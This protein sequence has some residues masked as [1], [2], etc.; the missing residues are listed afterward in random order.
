MKFSDRISNIKPSFIREIL[1]AS[2]NPDIIS[3][4]GGLPNKDYFPCQAL[5]DIT[6]TLMQNEAQ[7]LLQY[8][9]SEGEYQLRSLIS[10]RYHD[11]HQMKVPVDNILITNGSQ[12]AFDLIGKTLINEGDGIV[13]EAPAYLGAIQALMMYQPE[14]LPVPIDSNGLD[15]KALKQAM[16]ANPKIVYSVPN[17]Q[18]PTGFSYS[19]ENRES[20]VGLVRDQS[21]LIIEDDPYGDIRFNNEHP[22]S[23]YQYLPEQTILLG[24][25][26][27]IIS[28]GLR[29]GW[30]VAPPAVMEKL[31]IAKQ[32]S[33]LHT[34][35]L[36]QRIIAEY[37][38]AGHLP[39]HIKTLCEVYGKRC[40][41]MGEILDDLFG[42]KIERSY[43]QGGMFM[44]VKFP[45]SELSR[46]NKIKPIDTMAL[47]NKSYENGVAF[48]PGQPFYIETANQPNTNNSLRLNYSNGSMEQLKTGLDRLHDTFKLF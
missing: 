5:S 45:P 43:P 35:R 34:S 38:A 20:I 24:S 31:L 27:K 39:G 8:G 42:D 36:S 29:V 7:D 1:K 37:I 3:F 30:M 11:L 17:F 23:F 48:V 46:L 25:F 18:N 2:A 14:F 9:Q 41:G 28:P 15:I 47:F 16:M 44:W 32:A 13:I 10:Q 33:D 40:R 26:S 4:A 12:Q 22:P 21:C 19:V 6:S